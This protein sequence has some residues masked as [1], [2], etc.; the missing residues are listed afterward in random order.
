[1]PNTPHGL[2]YP[3]ATDPVAG[4]AAAIEALARA[5]E[6]PDGYELA[7]FQQLVDSAASGISAAADGDPL[8][9][10]AANTYLAVRHLLELNIKI[11]SAAGNQTIELRLHDGVAPGPLV[12]S[13]LTITPPSN[14]GLGVFLRLPF[15]P[16]AGAHTYQLRWRAPA[17]GSYTILGSQTPFVARIIK[18]H[19]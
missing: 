3:L 4:G 10:F 14:P 18:A 7:Y 15:V 12:A 17:A 5:A 8:V 16:T 19:S 2:P 13:M 6:T 11:I 9:N 1:M